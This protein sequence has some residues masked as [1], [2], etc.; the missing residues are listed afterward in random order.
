MAR[1]LQQS[2][3]ALLEQ[4]IHLIR[5]GSPLQALPLLEQS[6][7]QKQSALARSYLGMLLA[8][9]RGQGTTGVSLCQVS[10]D[11]DPARPVHYLNLAKALY[12]SDQKKLAIET[13]WKGMSYGDD[14]DLTAWLRSRG[15][16]K[17]PPIAF[18][19]RSNPLNRVLGMALSRIGLR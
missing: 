4:S 18:L 14:E 6:Y 1:N 17:K 11:E 5:N 2:P 12:A 16:R 10:L 13:A 15:I 9:E 3:D 8:T 7:R 19:S